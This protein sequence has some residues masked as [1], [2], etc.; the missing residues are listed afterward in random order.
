MVSALTET[1]SVG[2][3]SSSVMV[4]VCWV[5]MS[6]PPSEAVISTVSSASSMVSCTAITVAVTDVAPAASVSDSAL[7][8]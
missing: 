5:P 1:V 3:A 2:A 6:L 7:M 8:V 4:T